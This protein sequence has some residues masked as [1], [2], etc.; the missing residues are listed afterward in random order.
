MVAVVTSLVY[1]SKCEQTASSARVAKYACGL[2]TDWL[3]RVMKCREEKNDG[4]LN[5]ALGSDDYSDPGSSKP[6]LIQD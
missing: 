2:S 3:I 6:E 5:R 1:Q 4:L